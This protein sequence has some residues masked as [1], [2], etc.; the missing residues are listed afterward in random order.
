MSFFSLLLALLIE[1]V[2]PLARGNAV[3]AGM[4]SWMRWVV[5]KL[6]AGER[7]HGWLA[8]GFAVLL[9]SG[10]ALLI[11]WLLCQFVGWPLAMLWNVAVLYVTLGFRQ[12]SHHF[13]GIRDALE[14][15]DEDRARERLADWQQ[16]DV[17]ALPRSEIVRHVIEYSVLSAHRHVFGVLAWF[18][19]LAALGLGPTGAVL[20]RL[21]EFVSRYW[22]YKER[23][24][25]QPASAALQQ[26]SAQAWTLVDWLPVRMTA[27]SFAVVGSF[28]E[29]IEGWRFHA[30]RFPSDNDGV[31]LAATAGAINV[32]LGGEALP[33][34]ADPK[35]PQGLEIE[36]DMGDSDS[37][38]G[39]EPEVVHLRS[40]VGLVWRS[41]VVW[42]LLLALLTLARLLG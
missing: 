16:V 39:R 18:S 20:Y 35:T 21:A 31:V 3:H 6:D 41:V 40:V 26:A 1:Q 11:Y 28:E 37:T 22:Q 23:T 9:P 25:V 42:M 5:R 2:R 33:A 27:L 34:R 38:P 24:G 30:Q 36:A 19:V 32:Q 14:E 17:G 4:R 10:I 13:T 15:G 7:S 29:A 12:F 8:W